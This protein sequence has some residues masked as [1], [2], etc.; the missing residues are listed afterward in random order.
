MTPAI[1]ELQTNPPSFPSAPGPS[2]WSAALRQISETGFTSSSTP[3][4]QR[5]Y[6]PASWLGRQKKAWGKGPLVR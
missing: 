5:A 3:I 4:Q 1:C 2:S 6:V